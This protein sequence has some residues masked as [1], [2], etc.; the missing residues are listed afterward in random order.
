MSNANEYTSQCYGDL[1][2]VLLCSLVGQGFPQLEITEQDSWA[3]VRQMGEKIHDGITTYDDT[4]S[5]A[6]SRASFTSS[7]QLLKFLCWS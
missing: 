1:N 7:V 4:L 6:R 2:S 3:L 5:R